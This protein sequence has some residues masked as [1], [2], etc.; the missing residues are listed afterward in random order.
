MTISF[1]WWLVGI[2]CGLYVMGMAAL[3]Y[4]RMRSAR[5][6]PDRS[7]PRCISVVVPARNEADAITDCLDAL[8]DQ[9]LPSNTTLEIIVVDDQSSDATFIRAQRHLRAAVSAGADD[10]PKTPAHQVH[11]LPDAW[12]AGKEAAV[13]YGA[14]RATGA[15][16]LV[17]DAD[18]TPGTDWAATMARACTPDTPLVCGPVRYAIHKERW[19]ERFQALEFLGLNAYGAG[20]AGLGY[21]TI[22][23]GG[24]MAM[25][26]SLI[27]ALPNEHVRAHLAADELLVQHVAYRTNRQVR[28]LW[29]Q[30]ASVTTDPAP[31]WTAFWQQRK[32]WAHAMR[33]YQTV[34]W[35]FSVGIFV[36]HMVLLIA[37]GIGLS[38]PNALSQP[39]VAGLLAKMG[40]DLLLVLPASH[41]VRHRDLMRSYVPTSLLQLVYVVGAGLHGVFGVVRWKGRTVSE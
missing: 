11:R 14:D 30:D 1:L 15:V 25:H 22:C 31:T 41:T 16:V 7:L 35:L 2:T 33:S 5:A 27:D 6:L 34:P 36:V 10:L 4:G 32:R 40:G 38:D 24:N 18:C 9:T 3:A 20:T 23:N 29:H 21:P 39:A 8:H 13:A 26:C 37:C 12:G 28:Y 19:L 17:V